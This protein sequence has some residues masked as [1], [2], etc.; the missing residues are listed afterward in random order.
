MLLL[1]EEDVRK[2]TRIFSLGKG[3][4]NTKMTIKTLVTSETPG[5]IRSYQVWGWKRSPRYM[6]AVPGPAAVWSVSHSVVSDSLWPP[7][8]VACQT[9]LSVGFS[10]QEYWIGLP[11]RGSSQPR[12]QTQVSCTPGRFFTI[13]APGNA[14][15]RSWKW[16]FLGFNFLLY[17]LKGLE[18][19][20]GPD[21]LGFH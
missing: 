5:S 13:W 12:D 3:K 20:L 17:S 6:L 18:I 8:T 2:H 1:L 10:R 16:K 14:M 9:S 7:W 4:P 21:I 15:F 19:P 11:F